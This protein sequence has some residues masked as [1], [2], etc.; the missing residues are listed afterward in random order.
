MVTI[1]RWMGS[2]SPATTS[3]YAE[4]DVESKRK[5]VYKAIPLLN[6]DPD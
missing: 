2:A 4:G 5:A 1:S 3:I 6:T